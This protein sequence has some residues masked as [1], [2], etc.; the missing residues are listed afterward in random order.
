[1]RVQVTKTMTAA[2]NK[3]LKTRKSSIKSFIYDAVN[4]NDYILLCGEYDTFYN[5]RY[6][7]SSDDGT[8]KLIKVCY[9]SE[10]YALDDV[11]TTND[12]IKAFKASDHT[13]NG[14]INE[15]F[16]KYEI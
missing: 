11:I 5:E 10:C 7:Y 13:L 16:N 12:L 1:M 3:A 2:L 9:K 8:F 4:V 6:D 14:F 15:I